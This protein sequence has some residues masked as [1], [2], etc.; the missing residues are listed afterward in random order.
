MPNVNHRKAQE[1]H[2]RK[3]EKARRKALSALPPEIRQIVEYSP[4]ELTREALDAWIKS[5]ITALIEAA[6]KTPDPGAPHWNNLERAFCP[7]C[8]EGANP[9]GLGLVGYAIPKGLSDHLRHRGRSSPCRVIETLLEPFRFRL[10][11]V[12]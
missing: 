10:R 12:P 3:L 11:Y 4:D 2:L 1:L 6:P 7:L 5:A 8:G 9:L